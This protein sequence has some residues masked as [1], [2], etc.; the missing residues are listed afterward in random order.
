V[1]GGIGSTIGDRSSFATATRWR[2]PTAPARGTQPYLHALC[3]PQ[4]YLRTRLMVNE[5][6]SYKPSDRS[7]G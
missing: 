5:G 3:L 1:A 2:T 7:T 4:A 6:A